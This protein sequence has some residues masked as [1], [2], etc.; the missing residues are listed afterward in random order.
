MSRETNYDHCY[1]TLDLKP[2]ASLTEIKQRY[3]ELARRWHPDA[4]PPSQRDYATYQFQQINAAKDILESYW[5]QHNCAPPSESRQRFEEAIQRQQ[6]QRRQQTAST[7]PPSP[8]AP[9][10]SQHQ[11]FDDPDSAHEVWQRYQQRSRRASAQ[12]TFLDR[13]FIL[14]M[15]EASIF[16]ILWF[17]YSSLVDLHTSMLGLQVHSPNDLLFNVFFGLFVM[18]LLI[19]GYVTGIALII[20]AFLFLLVP[21]E[22]ILRMLSRRRK[23]PVNPFPNLSRSFPSRHK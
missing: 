5:E 21:Y 17:G 14:F 16:L 13:L 9:P 7:W 2:G 4:V 18:A 12:V 3:R 22:E 10:Q 6:T 1:Q 11:Q 8:N 23:R 19:G 15:A 20:L